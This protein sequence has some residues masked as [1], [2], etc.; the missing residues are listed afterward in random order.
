MGVARMQ[1]IES[2]MT[3]RK[4]IQHLQEQGAKHSRRILLGRIAETD[5]PAHH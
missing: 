3:I 5:P 4:L 2:D 1:A